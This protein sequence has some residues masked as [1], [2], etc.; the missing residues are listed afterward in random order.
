M[1]LF[2]TFLKRVIGAIALE[3][4]AYKYLREI[5]REQEKGAS[6]IYR[7]SYATDQMDAKTICLYQESDKPEA[8]AQH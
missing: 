3:V 8:P 2:G 4:S 6:K 5:V 1:R 7:D